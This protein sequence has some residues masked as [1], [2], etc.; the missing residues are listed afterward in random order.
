MRFD[1]VMPKLGE[2]VTEGTV[3]R[4]LK[5]VGDPIARDESVLEITT[6]ILIG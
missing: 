3:A 1:I 5:E 4:W 2:S 6:D